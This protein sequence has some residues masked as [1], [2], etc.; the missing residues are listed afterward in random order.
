MKDDFQ[1]AAIPDICLGMNSRLAS[2][3]TTKVLGRLLEPLGLDPTQFPIMVMLHLHPGMVVSALSI[4]LDIE[5][6]GISRNIQTLERKG[7]VISSGGRGRKGKQLTLSPT[8][9]KVFK[10]AVRCWNEAQQMLIAE[11]G[12]KEVNE[13]RQMMRNVSAAAQR[14]LARMD[15]KN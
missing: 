2:R 7:L 3:T 4:S 8:G 15:S 5:A 14:L 12:E 1:I 9:L 10:Q 6:S 11:L 13:A